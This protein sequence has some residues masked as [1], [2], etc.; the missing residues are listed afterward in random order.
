MEA[1]IAKYI[2][3]LEN[4]FFGIT[5]KELMR[6]AYEVAEKNNIPHVFNH[7]LKSASKTWFRKV[8]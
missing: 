2:L 3:A 1:K 8:L 6:L 7:E 4:M 5:R